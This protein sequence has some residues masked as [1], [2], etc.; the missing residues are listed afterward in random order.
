MNDKLG[1]EEG[2]EYLQSSKI[3]ASYSDSILSCVLAVLNNLSTLV[4]S[5]LKFA[6]VKLYSFCEGKTLPCCLSG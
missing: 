5:G 4:L 2:E 1:G 6:P 3:R